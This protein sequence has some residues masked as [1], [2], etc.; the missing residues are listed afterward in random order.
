MTR[1]E[2]ALAA[3]SE[4][5]REAFHR[6]LIGGT[7]ADWLSEVLAKAGTPVSSTMIKTYRAKLRREQEAP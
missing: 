2:T 3:M 5:A 7:S 4:P 6:H 1:I